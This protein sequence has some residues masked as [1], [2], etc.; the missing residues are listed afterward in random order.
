MSSSSSDFYDKLYA[1]QPFKETESPP[2]SE[3][4]Q[5][6]DMGEEYTGPR[7]SFKIPEPLPYFEPLKDLT[8]LRKVMS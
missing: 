1:I 7:F 5:L 3:T 6:P 2:S 8:P 4:K